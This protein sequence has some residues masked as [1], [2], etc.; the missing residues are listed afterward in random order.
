MPQDRRPSSIVAQNS[1]RL[2]ATSKGP[3]GSTEVR[4]PAAA[5]NF[6]SLPQS[7]SPS[8]PKFLTVDDDFM[9]E[10]SVSK[11][12]IIQAY[13]C[14][15]TRCAMTVC[16][17]PDSPNRVHCH[18]YDSSRPRTCFS[19]SPTSCVNSAFWKLVLSCASSWRCPLRLFEAI[20]ER[21]QTA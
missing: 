19:N 12:N 7:R 17:R 14:R 3:R 15:V 6:Q 11:A 13:V 9:L 2:Q 4:V 20:R 18:L 8:V 10:A 21:R 5:S 16:L 1:F